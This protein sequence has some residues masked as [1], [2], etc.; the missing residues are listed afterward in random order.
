LC[1]FVLAS[2]S[3]TPPRAGLCTRPLRGALPISLP[4]P[5]PP[6]RLWRRPAMADSSGTGRI[7]RGNGHLGL[8]QRL[9]GLLKTRQG[10]AHLRERSE[11][12]TSELQSR[13]NL[14]CRLLLEKKN[15][16]T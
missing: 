13:E 16:Y 9:R 2:L 12:H 1:S 10:E 15:Y 11:E 14:V 7:A 3:P 4:T 5:M 8:W 6:G